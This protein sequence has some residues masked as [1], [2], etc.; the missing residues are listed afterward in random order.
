MTILLAAIA[1]G[2]VPAGKAITNRLAL[3]AIAVAI[4]TSIGSVSGLARQALSWGETGTSEEL[5]VS[6]ELLMLL[7]TEV[8]AADVSRAE[9]SELQGKDLRASLPGVLRLVSL[10]LA[11]DSSSD[12]SSSSSSGDGGGVDSGSPSSGSPATGVGKHRSSALACAGA[13]F[14]GSLPGLGLGSLADGS[15]GPEGQV[16]NRSLSCLHEDFIIYIPFVHFLKPIVCK[17][18]HPVS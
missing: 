8:E 2:A 10:V 13:W 11:Q 1:Q 4:R 15:A 17:R 18:C 9:K 16:R 7:P 14:G 6:L 12:S 5:G 3:A